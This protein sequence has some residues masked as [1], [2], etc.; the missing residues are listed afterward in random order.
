MWLRKLI[1][2]TFGEP[3]K[4]ILEIGIYVDENFEK[5]VLQLLHLMKLKKSLK[6]KSL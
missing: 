5:K 2:P 6:I 4:D 1:N 3:S